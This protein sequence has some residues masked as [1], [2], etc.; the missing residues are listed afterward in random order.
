MMKRFYAFICLPLFLVACATTPKQT[1]PVADQIKVD[2]GVPADA[3]IYKGFIPGPEQ[4]LV[5]EKPIDATD[6]LTDRP[7]MQVMWENYLK[8]E[9]LNVFNY[10]GGKVAVNG[11]LPAE[12]GRWE[13][14]CTVRLSHMMH[15]AGHDIPWDSNK[16]VSGKYG[17]KY[18]Y[19]VSD[20][21]K[22]LMKAWGAPDVAIVDGTGNQYDLPNTPGI[23]VMDFPDGSF[24][25]HVTIWNGVETVD[26]S[27]IGGYRV[28]FWDLPCFMPGDR[29]STPP[30][31]S[32][33][34]LTDASP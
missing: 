23:V 13:N 10:I 16:T 26:E 34:S 3:A 30:V 22:Y 19:R 6:K 24:T 18:Y 7:N 11:N 31:A 28:I 33:A 9:P 15:M 14:A 2:P 4:T 25:G 29:I 27:N 32:I 12:K 5:C 8:D 1:A 21:E 20:M 17:D